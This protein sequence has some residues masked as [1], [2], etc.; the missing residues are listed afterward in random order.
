[1]FNLDPDIVGITESWCNPAVTDEEL[2]ITDYDLF[3]CDR[4]VGNKGGGVLLYV[5]AAL[6]PTEVQTSSTFADHICCK[7]NDLLVGVFYRSPNYDIV[8]YDNN[9]KLCQLITDVSSKHC[10]LMG[11][12]NF[13]HIDWHNHCVADSTSSEC[14]EF[15]Q[16]IEDSFLSQHVLEPTRGQSILDLVFTREPDLISH[17]EVI[18]NLGTSDHNMITFQIHQ[19]IQT[20]DTKRQYRD[21]YRGDYTAIK[22]HLSTIDWDQFMVG[23]T[24]SSWNKIKQLLLDLE[25]KFIP[26]KKYNKK[27]VNKPVWMTRKALKYVRKKHRVFMKYKNKDH[28]A[29]K[30]ANAKADKEIKRAK[31]KFE[32]K[33]ASNIKQDR[34]SFFAYAR[35]KSRCKKQAGSL[36]NDNNTTADTDTDIANCFNQYFASVFTAED[37]SNLPAS[38]DSQLSD[39]L[40]PCADISF[41]TDVVLKALSKLRSDKAMG[42]DGVSPRLLIETKE[43]I[44]YPLYLLFRKSLDE[45]SV[46]ADWKQGLVTPIHKKGNRNS[47]ENYRPVSLTSQICKLFESI[48]RDSIVRHLESNCLINDSQHGFRKG[49]SCL[50]NL[51]AFLDKVTGCLDSGEGVDVIFLDFAKAFDKVPHRRLLMKLQAHG[52]T[53]KLLDWIAEWLRCRI[54]RVGIRGTL[55][56][57]I[58]VL[59]GVPQGSVLG[60]ILFLVYINDLD[61]GIKNWILKFADD[62]KLF[63]RMSSVSDGNRLQDDLNK[64]VQWSQEWQMLFNVNKCSVMHI[65]KDPKL[66]QYQMNGQILNVVQQEKDLGVILCNNLKVSAQCQQACS[67]AL[68]IL[69]IINRTIIHRHTDILLKLY[70]SM[71]RPH[72]EYCVVAWSPHYNKDKVM[73]EKVQRRFTRMIPAV[74]NLP[75]ERRLAKLQM[76]TLEA[77]RIRADIIEVY[78]IIHGLSTVDFSCYFEFSHHERTRGHS[79]KLQKNRVLTDLRRHFFSERIVNIWNKLDED[80]V[81]APS[82]NSLK[83]KLNKLYT[84]ESLPGLHMS[85]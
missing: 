52:I 56:D 63:G 29:V 71:V 75:Y 15:Y 2:M 53:N 58:D 64:L 32:H 51:L 43:E 73:L 66:W 80:I 5:K 72:L 19:N 81:S 30:A 13:P 28:P 76:W 45:S 78:K 38:S 47:A 55:S 34:K 3:R 25:D 42:P 37:L 61:C 48:I 31:L 21:Y 60:P 8:G 23:D 50:T 10:L 62:T 70:K 20:F 12:F 14:K 74:K 7:I 39:E 46:P 6:R 26:M 77:R 22:N 57:W 17:Y 9:N 84:D 41:D 67:K 54:Q 59:S 24:C 68:Q 36:T 35:S 85:A 4:T 33:L 1:M 11:D 69:G 79:L 65:G 44:S 82:I 83:N 18:E 27:C 40:V 16:C 49:R